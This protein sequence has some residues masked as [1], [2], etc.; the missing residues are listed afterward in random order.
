MK[1]EEHGRLITDEEMKELQE[2]ASPLVKWLQDKFDPHCTVIVEQSYVKLVRDECGIP[3]E[4][5]D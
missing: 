3:F 5:K 2:L 1:L 4:V